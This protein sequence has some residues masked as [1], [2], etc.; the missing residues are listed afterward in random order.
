LLGDGAIGFA[1]GDFETLVRHGV[2][3]TAIVGNNGIWGLEKHPYAGVCSAT[4]W[5]ADL[6]PGIRYDKVVEAFGGH[7]ELVTAPAGIGPAL[8]PRLFDARVSLVN[9]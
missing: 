8:R 7:G 1:L 4:T 2:N 9:V 3:V 5:L 6:A